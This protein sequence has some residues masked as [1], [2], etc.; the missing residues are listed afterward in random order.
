MI[1][2]LDPIYDWK[3][4][5]EKRNEIPRGR[6]TQEKKN[7]HVKVELEQIFKIKE[8]MKNKRNKKWQVPFR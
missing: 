7:D 1:S 5:I 3:A 8:G 2:V 6:W 4:N